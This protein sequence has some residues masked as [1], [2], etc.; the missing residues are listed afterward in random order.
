VLIGGITK[1]TRAARERETELTFGQIRSSMQMYKLSMK[2]FPTTDQGLRALVENQGNPGWR[3]PYCEEEV[4][5]DAWDKDIQYES[6]GRSMKFTSAGEDEEFGTEDD[7][8]W[9]KED[10]V[11]TH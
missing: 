7:I 11:P 9:P 1:G 3:G 6:D 4:L 10:K 2:K 8:S 5:R